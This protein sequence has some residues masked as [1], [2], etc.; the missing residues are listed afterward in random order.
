MQVIW[1]F[2]RKSSHFSVD[3]S[4]WCHCLCCL[5]SWTSYAAM[6]DYISPSSHHL[7]LSV[8]H[9]LVF[10]WS[11]TNNIIHHF[12]QRNDNSWKKSSSHGIMTSYLQPLLLWSGVMLVCRY[13]WIN[14][15]LL[16]THRY[17]SYWYINYSIICVRALDPLTLSSEASQVVKQR[18]LNFMRSLSTVLAFAYCFSG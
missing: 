8:I 11:N 13:A 7:F 18:L 16:S 5:W 3:T 10:I 12:F 14:Y 17:L 1:C 2:A 4:S 15:Y 6:Q 9:G